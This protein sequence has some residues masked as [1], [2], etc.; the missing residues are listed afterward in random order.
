MLTLVKMVVYAELAVAGVGLIGIV[1]LGMVLA[2]RRQ[3]DPRALTAVAL[4]IAGSLLLA[5]LGA[6]LAQ[7]FAENAMRGLIEMPR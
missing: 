6:G 2:D 5:I 7:L 3:P 1:L 4:L